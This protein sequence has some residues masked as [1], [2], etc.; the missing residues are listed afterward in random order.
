MQVGLIGRLLGINKGFGMSRIGRYM[1]LKDASQF[2]TFLRAIANDVRVLLSVLLSVPVCL[3][4]S[5]CSLR[6]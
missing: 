5:L 2:A 4:H 3:T 1:L 6:W